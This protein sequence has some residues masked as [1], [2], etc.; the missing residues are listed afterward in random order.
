MHK[1][2]ALF[3]SRC[4]SRIFVL[5]MPVAL[6][7]RFR[8]P[9]SPGRRGRWARSCAP[10]QD[11]SANLVFFGDGST[12]HSASASVMHICIIG[13]EHAQTHNILQ[14]MRC[15]ANTPHLRHIRLTPGALELA[16]VAMG[17][18]MARNFVSAMSTPVAL[19]RVFRI[20]VY[21]DNVPCVEFVAHREPEVA[22]ARHLQGL[23]GFV[24]EQVDSLRQEGH[25]VVVDWASRETRGMQRAHRLASDRSLSD[26]WPAHLWFLLYVSSE[27][28][29]LA[30]ADDRQVMLRF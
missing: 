29:R 11:A 18:H 1:H 20:T 27:T 13:D 6:G 4:T 9:A 23:V 5:V 28:V 24:G 2:V 19:G 8:R 3:G 17:L 10:G 16:G 25:D 7:P 15:V 21:C 12:G 30:S 22:G 26:P 14:E